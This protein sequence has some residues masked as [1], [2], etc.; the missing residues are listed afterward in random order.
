MIYHQD[1]SQKD[2]ATKKSESI[3][4]VMSANESQENSAR[5][6]LSADIDQ[7][8]FPILYIS[9]IHTQCRLV[10][11]RIQGLDSLSMYTVISSLK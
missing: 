1:I 5:S 11:Q 8:S 4:L 9:D 2:V 7:I 6:D 3:V 10:K